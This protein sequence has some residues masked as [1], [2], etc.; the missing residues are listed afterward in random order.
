MSRNKHL[1]AVCLL[2]IAVGMVAVFVA[3]CGGSEEVTTTAAPATTATTAAPATDTTAVP[4]TEATSGSTE[5]STAGPATG[6]PIKIGLISSMTGTAADG[7]KDITN[8]AMA[9][10]DI[11][12]AEGGIN[13]RPIELLL[14]DDKSDVQALTAIMQKFGADK[15]IV[16]IVGPFFNPITPAARGLA[17]QQQIPTVIGSPASIEVIAADKQSPAKWSVFSDPSVNILADAIVKELQYAGLKN[18]IALCHVIVAEQ[19]ALDLAIPL[20]KTQGITITKLPDT[21]TPDQADFQPIVN[22]F[23]ETYN[24]LK[25]DGVVLMGTPN[26]TPVLTK[27]LRER[28]V[29]VPLFGGSVSAHPATIMIGGPDVEGLYLLDTGGG[30]VAEQMPGDW[31]V[32]ALQTKFADTFIKKFDYPADSLAAD[33]ASYVCV[34][35]EALKASGVDREKLSAALR[36]LKSVQTTVGLVTLSDQNTSEGLELGQMVLIQIKDGAFKFVTVL[37]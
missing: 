17:E 23:M 12:N 35:A 30:S 24:T 20:A 26:T 28:G 14:E 2:L 21:F 6:E 8:G 19:Q 27:M 3:A 4:S 33:G 10:A 1:I 25:P 13:G 15:S 34:V 36:N 11:I 32:K 5:T 16:G 18:V 29:T 22:K 37:K 9:M 31:A 7:G